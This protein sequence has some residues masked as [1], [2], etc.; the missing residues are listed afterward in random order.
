MATRA[1]SVPAFHRW[2]RRRVRPGALVRGRAA[3]RPL[4]GLV[5]LASAVV[6]PLAASLAGTATPVLTPGA[7]VTSLDPIAGLPET[8]WPA[9]HAP[10]AGLVFIRCTNLWTMLP[11]GSGEHRLF[12]MP[13]ISSPTFSPDGRTI[14]FL[15]TSSVGQQVWVAAAD[16][17]ARM[18]VG[19]L[20]THGRP[21]PQAAGLTW[22]PDGSRL[23]FALAPPSGTAWSVWVLDVASG[24]LEAAGPGGPAPFWVDRALLDSSA[25]SS[26][27][28]QVLLGH[29]R[30]EAKRLSSDQGDLA[31]GLSPGWWTDTW[32]KDTA[33]VRSDRGATEL[34]VTPSPGRRHGVVT[35]PPSGERIEPFARPAVLEGGPVAVTLLDDQGGRDLGLFD[36][37]T[38][39]WT[40]LDYAWDPTWSPAPPATGTL[41]AE[42]AS[43][44]V[45]HLLGTWHLHPDRAAL[46]LG[47]PDA[48]NLVS[49]RHLGYA[50]GNPVH[51]DGG[52][53]VPA[54]VFGGTGHGFAYRRVSF[55]V[56][57]RAGRLV[58]TPRATSPLGHVRTI[59]QA[60]ALLRSMLTVRV[61]SPAGL[62]A[63]TRLAA[64]PLSAWSWGRKT[65]GTLNLTVLN[66]PHGRSP[67]TV[68]YGGGGFG[69]GPSPVPVRLSTGTSAI[70][71]DPTEVS[72]YNQVAWPASP[73]DW[74]GPFGVSGNLPRET[75]I[76]MA[77]AMDA[78]RLAAGG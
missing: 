4:A 19:T 70:A 49:F 69:C 53:S 14:A 59:D 16:G 35:T 1:V 17:S 8:A 13:G 2:V 51:R 48:R 20:L 24:R 36:P 21:T 18:L 56:A 47:N 60:V 67:L 26:P 77:D 33:I 68:T 34:S 38:E 44:L 55:V 52:W 22:S 7:A 61:V 39:R 41:Q 58:V 54:T 23:A 65:T 46:V 45:R 43:S 3:V 9:S 62:P 28:F 76:G 37:T 42:A 78:K 66:A 73:K 25:A 12:S 63:A 50:F 72:G 64:Q 27:D 30:W 71:T 74:N 10:A 75:I 31:A 32:H 29:D 11:D 57:A 5:V 40:V 6:A 15:A